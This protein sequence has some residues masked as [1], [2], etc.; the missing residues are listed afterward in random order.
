MK[1]KNKYKPG[2]FYHNQFYGY[3]LWYENREK[4]SLRAE[5]NELKK[6][7]ENFCRYGWKTMMN[8][9]FQADCM[10][11]VFKQRFNESI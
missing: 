3:V 5:H 11:E 1:F 8:M 9:D 7:A 10:A 4:E 6:E 2:S